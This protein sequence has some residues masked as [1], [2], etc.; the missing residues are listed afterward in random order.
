MVNFLLIA[1]HQ[2]FFKPCV[3]LQDFIKT[4]RLVLA[5]MSING[6]RTH[7]W[8]IQRRFLRICLLFMQNTVQTFNSCNSRSDVCQCL[9]VQTP[10]NNMSKNKPNTSMIHAVIQSKQR[11]VVRSSMLR[12]LVAIGRA[13]VYYARLSTCLVQ[14]LDVGTVHV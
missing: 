1:L 11:S 7:M 12:D 9:V 5:A 14:E 13:V 4:A 10:R 2:A 8:C 6:F 3:C